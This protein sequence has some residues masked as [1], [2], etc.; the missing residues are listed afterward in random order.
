MHKVT[1]L[2]NNHEDRSM[3]KEDAPIKDLDGRDPSHRFVQQILIATK[4]VA[5]NERQ[6]AKI[7]IGATKGEREYCVHGCH[8]QFVFVQSPSSL[9]IEKKV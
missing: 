1:S 6:K 5:R 7:D 2:L 3:G 8:L 9:P 4:M